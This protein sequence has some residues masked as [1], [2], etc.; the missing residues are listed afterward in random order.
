MNIKRPHSHRCMLT[1]CWPGNTVAF[2]SPWVLPCALRLQQTEYVHGTA[3][4]PCPNLHFN[5]ITDVMLQFA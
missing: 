2:A 1:N 5:C 4:A 3:L